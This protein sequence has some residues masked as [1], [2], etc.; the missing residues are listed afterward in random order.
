MIDSGRPIFIVGSMPPTLGGVSTHVERLADY[1]AL[2]GNA[3]TVFDLYTNSRTAV[4]DRGY[5]IFRGR[6]KS[7][8][9]RLFW[10]IIVERPLLVHVHLSAGHHLPF[11]AAPFVVIRALSRLVLTVHSGS[12]PDKFQRLKGVPGYLSRIALCASNRIICVS[13]EISKAVGRRFPELRPKLGVIIP[14]IVNPI[15]KRQAG[16]LGPGFVFLAA[17]SGIPIYDWITF[18]EACNGAK[19][20]GDVHL[21]FYNK[22][23][24]EYFDRIV[25]MCSRSHV[26]YVIH[27]G[28]QPAEFA[29]LLSRVSCFVRPTLTDGDSIAVREALAFGLPVVASDAVARPDGCVLFKTGSVQELQRALE[30]IINGKVP[31]LKTVVISAAPLIVEEYKKIH[32]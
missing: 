6:T 21:A 19:G 23:E 26:N 10:K 3:V 30:A 8:I 14:F 32:E 22:S 2:Q 13:E 16:G 24:P 17:G 4:L 1:L 11:L 28:M 27:E 15:A 20:I 29:I 12:A 31:E 5:P 25:E 18:I 9:V 7:A